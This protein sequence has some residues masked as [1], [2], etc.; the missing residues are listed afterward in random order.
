[1]EGHRM[2]VTEMSVVGIGFLGEVGREETKRVGREY[3]ETIPSAAAMFF[4]RMTA[5]D[6]SRT[7]RRT[8]ASD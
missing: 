5:T 8:L 1:M 7:S 4:S 3:Q 6:V 2:A